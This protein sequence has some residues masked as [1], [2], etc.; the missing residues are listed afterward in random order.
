MEFH[1]GS[2]TENVKMNVFFYQSESTFEHCVEARIGTEVIKKSM[3]LSESDKR[4]EH[5]G[6]YF[7]VVENSGDRMN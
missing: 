7:V 6:H 1:L 4:V 3:C 2:H 5:V